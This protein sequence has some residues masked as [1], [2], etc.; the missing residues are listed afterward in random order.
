MCSLNY[1]FQCITTMTVSMRLF[2]DNSRSLQPGVPSSLSRVPSFTAARINLSLI[3]LRHA[4]PFLGASGPLMLRKV[5]F[6]EFIQSI[7]N[8]YPG[9]K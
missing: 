2:R 9:V 6:I 8:K 1:H 7:Y 3:K 4:T 5:T